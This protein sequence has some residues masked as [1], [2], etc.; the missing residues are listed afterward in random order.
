MVAGQFNVSNSLFQGVD[1]TGVEIGTSGEGRST[2]SNSAFFDVQGFRA[3][4]NPDGTPD[5]ATERLEDGRGVQISNT[6]FTSTTFKDVDFR[7][8]GLESTTFRGC[9]LLNVDLTNAE[10][11]GPD[12]TDNASRFEPT[13]Q[14]AILEGVRLDG[15]RLSNVSFAG[16]D[17]SGG[18]ISM[19][20]A[21]LDNVDFTGATGLQSVNWTEVA[22]TGNVYGLAE[23][24][25]MLNL[26]R[27]E[28]LR[29]LTFDGVV[30]EIDPESGFDVEPLTHWL[31]DPATGVRFQRDGFSGSLYPIDP[32]TGEA[33]RDPQTGDQLVFQDGRLMNPETKETFEVEYE[34]G[35]LRR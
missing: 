6:D 22:V 15:A 1:M 13:F 29:S 33:M 24:G 34:S 4:D 10:I 30:P 21:V 2:I 11:R 8:A 9:G 26:Q 32:A 27:P 31:I 3:V 28:L 14:N 12:P 25:T 23:Y 35:E 7:R 19:E 5:T 18:G 20:G 17:F 16:V